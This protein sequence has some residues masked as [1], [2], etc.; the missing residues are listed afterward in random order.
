MA[1]IVEH[2]KTK[3]RYINEW[4]YMHITN[5]IP[6]VAF[7]MGAAASKAQKNYMVAKSNGK[8]KS[9]RGLP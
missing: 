1:K 8:T 6:L 4:F 9:V 2:Y 7:D 3:T 5:I